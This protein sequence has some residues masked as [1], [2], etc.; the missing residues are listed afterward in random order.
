MTP[1]TTTTVNI[2]TFAGLAGINETLAGRWVREAF[3]GRRPLP[4]PG[5]SV[6]ESP[7]GSL[8]VEVP[9]ACLEPRGAVPDREP[10]P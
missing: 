4:P 6:V 8:R 5:L 3:E 10:S 2:K 9:V 1:T 7:G